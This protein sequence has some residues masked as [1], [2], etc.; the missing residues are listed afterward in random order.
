MKEESADFIHDACLLDLGFAGSPFTW[1]N[2][3]SGVARIYKRLDR[4]LVNQ[5][6][7]SLN[8]STPVSHLARIASDHAPLLLEVKKES[9]GPQKSFKFLNFWVR[10]RE[11]VQQAWDINVSGD[12][13]RILILK[14]KQVKSALKMWSC[15]RIGDIF[16]NLAT[17]ESEVNLIEEE[18]R[19]C[20]S[21]E[22][23]LRLNKA[24]MNLIEASQNVAEY[25]HQKARIKWMAVGDANSAYLHA[26]VKAKRCERR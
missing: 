6:W 9:K 10:L 11:V 19:E 24:K 15:E 25:W 4:I 23:L 3:R 5:S 1:C 8:V 16:S 26:H 20:S 12:P 22:N 7:L 18:V 14:L 21:E 2:N 17:A 13:M